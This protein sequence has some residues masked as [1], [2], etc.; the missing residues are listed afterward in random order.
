MKIQYIDVFVRLILLFLAIEVNGKEAKAKKAKK[1]E[2]A[3]TIAPGGWSKAS[4][5]RT[6]PVNKGSALKFRGS[7]KL[8]TNPSI[9]PI[10]YGSGNYWDSVTT[11]ILADSFLYL[12]E[13]SYFSPV[14]DLVE[15]RTGSSNFTMKKAIY[16][17]GPATLHTYSKQVSVVKLVVGDPDVTQRLDVGNT[18]VLTILD[19]KYSQPSNFKFNEG[20]S[21]DSQ[22]GFCGYHSSFSSTNHVSIPFSFIGSGGK[23][24][25]WGVPPN[26]LMPN[27]GWDDFVMSVF[28]HELSEMLTN[29]VGIG[30]VDDQNLEIGDKCAGL[31]SGY[32]RIGSTNRI[33]N[34]ILGNNH[35]LV[36]AQFD[37]GTDSCLAVVHT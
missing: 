8:Y 13:N 10:F 31:I 11:R 33:Y 16:Y 17:Y 6:Y 34:M 19:S 3:N 29:P 30:F 37:P 7:D 35:F 15:S 21:F 12:S 25:Q 18:F 9:L 26:Y 22:N 5:A 14:L 4:G 23:L 2:V 27:S 36:Q 32:N 28:L 20:T 1:T 24:C